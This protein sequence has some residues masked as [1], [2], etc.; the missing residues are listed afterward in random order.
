MTP[1][2]DAGQKTLQR[3]R[4][5][6]LDH[7]AAHHLDGG[8]GADFGAGD[9]D[10]HAERGE[11]RSDRV[12]VR[13][14][15]Q[16]RRSDA[17]PDKSAPAPRHRHSGPALPRSFAVSCLRPGE[18]ELMSRK[19]GAPARCAL[20]DCAAST[21]DAAV[22]AEMIRSAPRDRVRGRTGAAHSRRFGGPLELFARRLRK[23]N[24]PGRHRLDAGLAQSGGYG[25]AG[26][27]E[28]D[29]CDCWL[30]VW[31]GDGSLK[32]TA[33]DGS[34]GARIA[35]APVCIATPAR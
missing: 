13:A 19:Y 6:A 7:D 24:V 9:A 4:L 8:G 17:A 27:A 18:T 2:R 14:G 29:E 23:Q 10:A 3:Q 5:D 15:K 33:N 16:H 20:T 32:S 35:M 11:H 26:F 21:L 31:H 12:G 28:A 22:T 34:F 1:A 25:L 30:A